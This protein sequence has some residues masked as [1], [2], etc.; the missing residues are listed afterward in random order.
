MSN[1]DLKMFKY[2]VNEHHQLWSSKV[3]VRVIN[4][5]ATLHWE[6]G[7]DTVLNGRGF[8]HLL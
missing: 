5:I 8:R 7:L 3:Y 6:D 1:K 2:L 4:K